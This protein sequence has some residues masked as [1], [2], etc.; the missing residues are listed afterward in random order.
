MT[1]NQKLLLLI[2]GGVALSIALAG[3]G[4]V[5]TEYWLSS[6]NAQK[7]ASALA[8]AEAQYGL[9]AGLLSRI[10]YQE[11]HFRSDIIDGTTASP[12][13]A[14]GLMQ[15]M[16]QY[17]SSVQVPVPFS[18]SDTVAQIGQAAQLLAQ[19]YARF[20]DWSLAIAAYNDGAGNVDKYVNGAIGSLPTETQNYVAAVAADLP[21][22]ASA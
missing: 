9:P 7:W 18:D 1:D 2:I 20:Q 19:D 5:A 12:A 6:A 8:A 13:G 10:A 16:P 3:G 14:L 15:L 4:Y 11:S 21:N 17:F 22:L